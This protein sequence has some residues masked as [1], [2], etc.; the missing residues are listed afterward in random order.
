[1]FRCPACHQPSISLFQRIAASDRDYPAVCPRCGSHSVTDQSLLGSFAWIETPALALTCVIWFFTGD[2][3]LA[4]RI[5]IA[6]VAVL[7]PVS[8]LAVPL[9]LASPATAFPDSLGVIT[10][11]RQRIAPVFYVA[12]LLAGF[13]TVAMAAAT[14]TGL[15]P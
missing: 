6:S 4:A 7:L 15:L 8:V 2:N 11:P 3:L 12:I 10:A 5:A 14:L 1:M 13:V 9:R